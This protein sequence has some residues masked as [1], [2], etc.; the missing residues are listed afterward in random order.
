MPPG[1]DIPK[2][3]VQ[4]DRVFYG[5]R[6]GRRLRAGMEALLEERL[7]ELLVELPGTPDAMLDPR[8]LF[9]PET[10]GIWLEIGFGGGEHLAAQAE[11]NPDVGFIGSEPFMNGVASLLRHCEDRGLSNV[12]IYP[13][14]VRDLL[15][16]LPDGCL[17][18]IAVLFADPWPKKRHHPRRIIQHGTIADFHRLLKPGGELR[19][20]TDD[21][22]YLR[23]MLARATAH[24][25]FRWLARG[26]QDWRLRPEDWPE[27]RYEAK[28]RAQGRQPAFMRF[29]RLDTGG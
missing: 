18:R 29:E 20:A 13:D 28:A 23:W 24:R 9:P 5:R 2:D 1:K 19:L 11:A 10:R 4:R 25:G 8:T 14:D 21:M 7:P 17:D 22:G 15:A 6:R 12:R 26:P 27:T 3:I 16:V